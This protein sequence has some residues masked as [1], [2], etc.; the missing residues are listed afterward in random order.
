MS[1][2]TTYRTKDLVG[3]S[4]DHPYLFTEHALPPGGATPFRRHDDDLRSFVVIGGGVDLEVFH[5][6]D[7]TISVH[8]D[9]LAGWHAPPGS[10]YRLVNRTDDETLVVEAGTRAGEVVEADDASALVPPG[11]RPPTCTRTSGY[12][13]DKPWGHEVWYTQNLD[14]PPYALKQIHMTSGHQSSLQ[15]HRFK[16]ETNYV[17]DGEA[18]VLN[19]LP[20]PEDLTATIDVDRIP[21]STRGPRTGWSS[22]PNVL[23]RVIARSTYTSIEVSTNELDDVIR[24]QDDSGRGHGRIDGEHEGSTR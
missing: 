2:P 17:I 15:S 1:A 19:G 8:H 22:A 5:S 10:V 16:S 24:W 3:D 14:D 21:V 11:T 12:T 18:T 20:A 4:P 23:H 6:D 7:D 9:R 13:V